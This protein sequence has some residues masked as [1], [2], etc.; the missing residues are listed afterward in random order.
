MATENRFKPTV[1][2]TL[3]KRAASHCSN[4]ECNALTSGPSSNPAQVINVGEAAHISGANPG[5]A[6]Y[7][8][9][10]TEAERSDISNAIWLCS[11]CHKMIDDDPAKYPSD[12]LYA[13]IRD[14]E[15]KM[16]KRVGKNAATIRHQYESRHIEELGRM[17]YRAE[18][19]II[20]KDDMWEYLLI[21][22]SLRYKI[23]PILRRW[24][25]LHKN[26]YTKNIKKIPTK[27]FFTWFQNKLDEILNI[28]ASIVAITS[29]ELNRACGAPGIS[30]NE[31]D[32]LY[33]CRLCAEAC[34]RLLEWEESVHFTLVDEPFK[35]VHRHLHGV[36]GA[37]ITR[38]SE[39]PKA[40]DKTIK[41]ATT[42]GEHTLTLT[43]DLPYGWQESVL[44]SMEL[45]TLRI[46]QGY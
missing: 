36:A 9:N 33:A 32:I 40:I 37:T 4:P 14:H 5:S 29:I 46:Q 21:A 26:L 3:A 7:D 2:A 11:N 22:E 31:S 23:A 17:S 18:R 39:L 42:P 28:I 12:L 13:W 30:G 19:L 15:E 25:A 16:A 24:N 34:Q 45:A 6:R 8:S 35:D 44:A 1:I 41:N 20:N 43:I 38:I 27:H 10:M